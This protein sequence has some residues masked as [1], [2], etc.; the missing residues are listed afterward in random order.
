MALFVAVQTAF[1]LVYVA[2]TVGPRGAQRAVE[3]MERITRNGDVIAVVTF[4]SAPACLLALFVIVKV[5]RGATP[6][7][8]L[9]LRMPDPRVLGRWVLA[10]IAFAALSDG[11]TWLLGKP[12]VPEFMAEAYRSADGKGA[13]WIALIIAAPV[14]EEV[15]FRGFVITGVAASRLGAS[16]AIVLSSLAWAAIHTQ[17]DAY[18]IA[19]VFALGILL[20]AA[21][22]NTRS[23]ATPLAMHMAANL[24][25]TAQAAFA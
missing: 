13:L 1:A 6:E 18:G 22:V 11:L 5:K 23:I 12:I 2:A 15:F 24:I 17:Y 14:F 25:A 4:L 16:G 8:S 3:E 10:I 20:G 9:A 21:R 7:D 19:T